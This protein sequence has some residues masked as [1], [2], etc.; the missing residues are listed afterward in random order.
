MGCSKWHGTGHIKRWRQSSEALEAPA[1][2][3][4]EQAGRRGVNRLYYIVFLGTIRRL[5]TCEPLLTWEGLPGLPAFAFLAFSQL[6]SLMDAHSDG[7]EAM[8]TPI[9]SLV[10][11][12][13]PAFHTASSSPSATKSLTTGSPGAG[14]KRDAIEKISQKENLDLWLNR[15]P[16]WHYRSKW[17]L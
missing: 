17:C 14:W 7:A 1:G 4:D 11:H 12:P 3:S 8:Q 5:S 15:S 16:D 13:A 10:L 2:R 6:P 9:W